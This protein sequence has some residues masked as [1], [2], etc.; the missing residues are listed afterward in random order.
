[1]HTKTQNS[2]TKKPVFLPSAMA[3]NYD[4]NHQI[5]L[6]TITEASDF[7]HKKVSTI[8][9]DLSRRP[10]CLPPTLDLPGS[11]KVLFVNMRKWALDLFLAQQGGVPLTTPGFIPKSNQPVAVKMRGRPTKV[12]AAAKLAAQAKKVA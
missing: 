8:Y 11:S 10:E 2:I 3:H 4:S 9:S 1:M 7:F 12:E 5:E 6:S